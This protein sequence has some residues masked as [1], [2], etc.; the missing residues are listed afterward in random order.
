MF[1]TLLC[2]P[3]WLQTCSEIN[4]HA[5]NLNMME[6][7]EEGAVAAITSYC[8][9]QLAM[10]GARGCTSLALTCLNRFREPQI[11]G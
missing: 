2:E 8:L 5:F 9:H 11:K 4:E 1:F 6:T 3:C 10:G 7:Q